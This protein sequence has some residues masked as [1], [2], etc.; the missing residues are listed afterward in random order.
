MGTMYGV[1]WLGGTLLALVVAVSVTAGSSRAVTWPC[2]LPGSTPLWVD[3]TDGTVPF[4]RQ[5]FAKPGLVMATPPGTGAIPSALRSAGAS[6]IFFDLKLGSRVGTPDAPA[7]PSTIVDV[8]NAEFDA[9]VK[10]TGCATPLIAENELFGATTQT[11][12]SASNTTYRANV[13]ALLTQ[14]AARGAHPYLL[15]SSPPY[16][17]DT[18]G[19]W[20]RS[21]AQVSDIVREFFPNPPAVYASGPVAGSRTLRVQMRQAVAAFT[22]M[23][24]PTSRLG[25]ML[26]FE[27]GLYGRNGLNPAAA[28]YDFVKLDALAARQV[29]GELGIPTIWSWG[30][31]TYTEKSPFDADKANAACVYLWARA[32]NLCDGPTAAGG[33][34]DTSL[35][36]GQLTLP[37]RVFCTLGQAGVIATATREQLAAVTGD[38]ETAGTIALGWGTTRS[39]APVTGAQIDAAENAV[40][41]ASFAGSRSR[42]LAAL[43]RRHA[44]RG[45]ARAA[46]AAELR[47]RAVESGLAIPPVTAAAVA[48][49]WG[50][51]A[52]TRARLVTT[53]VPVPWLGNTR[54]GFA[55]EG[56][57]PA[58]VFSLATGATGLVSMP[59]GAVSVKALEP[60]L[61]LAAVTASKA[62]PSVVAALK[63]LARADAYQAWLQDQ[64]AKV[65]NATVCADDDVPQATPVALEDYLTFLALS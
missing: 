2:G 6:T 21:V 45:L 44:N 1:R 62:R 54:R 17:G 50:A 51:Y 57:A 32:Q 63:Q 11:P 28:W 52:A 43:S 29:A 16:G 47:A 14:L 39:V 41:A 34:F 4:W 15:I 19:D 65:L 23:G 59:T 46:L 10:Q 40:I 9:A 61:P 3:Y 42:Y 33:G 48:E 35:T 55:L 60:P 20:W 38:V 13:L 8:A 24:I 25:L 26:E 56:F 58:R 27:Y 31:A 22:S 53:K 49:F 37:A 36:E 64:E 18:A 7:D 30:W 12:W 5:V